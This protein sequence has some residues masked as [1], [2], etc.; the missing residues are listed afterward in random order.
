VRAVGSARLNAIHDSLVVTVK[1]DPKGRPPVPPRGGSE[2]DGVQ[3]LVLDA[4]VCLSWGP[5]GAEP[6]P[7][8]EC[9][10]PDGPRAVGEELEVG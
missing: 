7:L 2:S 1:P 4:S 5:V 9:P 8:A 6:L 3:L 10:K